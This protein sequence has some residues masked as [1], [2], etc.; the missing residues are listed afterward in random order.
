MKSKVDCSR[1]ELFEVR[2]ALR[3]SS[4]ICHL[5]TTLMHNE[6]NSEEHIKFQ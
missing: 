3:K 4:S 5:E 2:S 6:K 1:L